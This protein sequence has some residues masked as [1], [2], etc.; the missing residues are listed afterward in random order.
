MLETLAEA[1]SKY[2]HVPEKEDGFKVRA[3]QTAGVS[4]ESL[5]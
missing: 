3:E 1:L 4:P 2:D 5:V